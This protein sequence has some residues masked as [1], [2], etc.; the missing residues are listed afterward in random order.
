MGK[1]IYFTDQ[2]IKALQ[3]IVP[4]FKS[5]HEDDWDSDEE[6]I[7]NGMITKIDKTP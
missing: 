5:T 6:I 7:V 1:A 2:E 4:M 3:W